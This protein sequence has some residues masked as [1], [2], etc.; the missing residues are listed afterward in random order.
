MENCPNQD[1]QDLRINRIILRLASA[2]L[3][4]RRSANKFC[5]SKNPENPDSDKI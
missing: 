3:S 4:N 5:K 2:P 1:L